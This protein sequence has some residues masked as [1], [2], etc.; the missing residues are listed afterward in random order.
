[1]EEQMI[2]FPLFLSLSPCLFPEHMQT[3]GP[4][5]LPPKQSRVSLL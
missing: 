1:M 2:S 4:L 5:P 3:L